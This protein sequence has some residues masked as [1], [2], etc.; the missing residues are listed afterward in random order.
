MR[1]MA[2]MVSVRPAGACLGRPAQVGEPSAASPGVSSAMPGHHVTGAAELLRELPAP[3]SGGRTEVGFAA[4]RG[5]APRH[6][7]PVAR[8]G[9]DEGDMQAVQTGLQVFSTAKA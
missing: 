4:G 7:F 1:L 3:W 8:W 6:R 9:V 5:G 2:L